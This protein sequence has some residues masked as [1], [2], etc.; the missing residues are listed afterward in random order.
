MLSIYSLDL[1]KI[2]K[3]F[4]HIRF[5]AVQMDGRVEATANMR[6]SSF[7]EIFVLATVQ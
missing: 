5:P 1:F 3:L 7:S 4:R 2:H 6:K